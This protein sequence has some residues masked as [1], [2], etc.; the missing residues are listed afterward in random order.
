MHAD[1]AVHRVVEEEDDRADPL[2]ERGRQLLP[3]HHKAAVAA[4]ADDEPVGMDELGGDRGRDAIAH[5]TAR[6]PEL[7]ARDGGIAESGWASR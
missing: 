3:G 2:G 1:R 6:R 4:K 5:R 7:A